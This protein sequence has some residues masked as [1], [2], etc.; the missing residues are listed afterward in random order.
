MANQEFPVRNK[1]R[2]RESLAPSFDIF[3]T[4]ERKEELYVD[5]TEIRSDELFD[6]LRFFLGIEN[7]KLVSPNSSFGT[8]IIFSGHVGCGKTIELRRFHESIHTPDQYFSI[9]IPINKE[10]HLEKF[11]PEDFYLLVI[12][13]FMNALKQEEMAFDD[14]G[15]NNIISDWLND[16][17]V[18][19]ELTDLYKVDLEAEASVG[20][21]FW[22]FIKVSSS[23]KSLFSSQSKT[24]KT[25]RQK[26]R[27][28]PMGLIKRFNETIQSA[29]DNMRQTTPKRDFLIIVDDAE[30]MKLTTHEKVF[31]DNVNLIASIKANMICTTRIDYQLG[32][33]ALR[34]NFEPVILP[35]I[36]LKEDTEKAVSRLKKIITFRIQE[37]IFFN[38]NVLNYCVEQSG[39]HP[40][41]LIKIVHRAI[42]LSRGQK[43]DNKIAEKATYQ[44]GREIF[45]RLTTK[46][47]ER[48]KQSDQSFLKGR[49]DAE[50]RELLVH[51]CLLK[52][53][54]FIRINPLLKP[55]M[56]I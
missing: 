52:Y 33:T 46:H 23:I 19:K 51:L 44:L 27:D 30:K 16:A 56:E 14:S 48:L 38:D 37:G 8:K 47:Y 42:I 10:V 24:I 4:K 18:K 25:V 29:R 40:R 53:N 55:F 7:K 17:E 35:M 49:G 22:N 32:E 20:A 9:F 12:V 5:L 50:I 1:F 54:G 21:G 41:Q 45:D 2:A 28:N 6:N 11:E 15:L 34:N 31:E 3:E 26:V 13:K 39:G 36:D 43:I